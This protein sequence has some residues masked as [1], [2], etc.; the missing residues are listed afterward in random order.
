MSA[1]PRDL[2]ALRDD[3]CLQ[4]SGVS[5]P[6]SGL[7]AGPEIEAYVARAALP[8]VIKDWFLVPRSP[9]G[10]PKVL[11]HAA[12]VLPYE[13]PP[14]AVASDLAVPALRS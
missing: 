14:V 8:G 13:I 9:G 7:V 2:G 10:R 1:S 6:D 12:D 5:H 4:L 11:L 3:S